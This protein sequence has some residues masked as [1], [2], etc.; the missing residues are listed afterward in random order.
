M[1]KWKEVP[2]ARELGLK[3]YCGSKA[4]NA[5]EL[6]LSITG[7]AKR[8]INWPKRKGIGTH[9]HMGRKKGH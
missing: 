2:N 1:G 6:G 8:V 3:I 7:D 4:P 5:K 9:Y